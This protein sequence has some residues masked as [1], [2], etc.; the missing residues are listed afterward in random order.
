MFKPNKG[1]CIDCQRN[2]IIVVKKGYCGVC[3]AKQKKAKKLSEGKIVKEYTYKRKVTG[4]MALF[5]AI[6]KVRRHIC[7]VCGKVLSEPLKP[8][9]FA[10]ILSK[11]AF[12]SYRLFDQNIALMCEDHHNQYDSG[13]SASPIFDKINRLKQHLKECY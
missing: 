2:T 12:P 8:H 11:G 1:T 9:Y 3:N 4:E 5:T 7:S 6:W 10:H 13:D